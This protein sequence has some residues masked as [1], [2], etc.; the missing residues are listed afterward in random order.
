MFGMTS[1]LPASSKAARTGFWIAVGLGCLSLASA[2]AA[3]IPGAFFAA[4]FFAIAWGI[5]R[6]QAWAA[7]TGTAV[8]LL[9]ILAIA[10]RWKDF[11]STGVLALVVDGAIT[12]A[13]LYGMARSIVALWRDREASRLAWPWVAVL[14]V[15]LGACL[16]VRPYV[17]PTGSMEN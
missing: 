2:L 8:L 15:I 3:P 17:L 10:T 11:S 4:L 6:R 12:L 14:A 1:Q 9:P 13:C 16:S 7:I 5:R